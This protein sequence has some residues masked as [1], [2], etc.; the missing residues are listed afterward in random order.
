MQTAGGRSG[1]RIYHEVTGKDATPYVIGGGTYARH[2][3]NAVGF[4]MEILESRCPLGAA[5]EGG[6][7]PPVV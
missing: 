4:G 3:Q 5:V 6:A 7:S 1:C 2:L